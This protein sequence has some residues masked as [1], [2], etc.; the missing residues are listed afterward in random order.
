M[1]PYYFHLV[2]AH[3]CLISTAAF[4]RHGCRFGI[5]LVLTFVHFVL[6]G[7]YA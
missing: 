3:F 5:L 2:L 7:Y 1:N 6:A 4:P